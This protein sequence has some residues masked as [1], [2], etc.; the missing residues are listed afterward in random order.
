MPVRGLV[1]TGLLH[2][3][4]ALWAIAEQLGVTLL[5]ADNH[6]PIAPGLH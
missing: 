3:Q 6:A 4:R 5:T 1:L 2:E